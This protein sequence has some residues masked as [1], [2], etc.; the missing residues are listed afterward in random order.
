MRV[1][2]PLKREYTQYIIPKSVELYLAKIIIRA[3]FFL[4][5]EQGLLFQKDKNNKK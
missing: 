4:K 5:E 3:N 1:Q 2:V